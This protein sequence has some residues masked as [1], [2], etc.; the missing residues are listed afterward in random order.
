MVPLTKAAAQL[1]V[2][3]MASG[4]LGEGSVL[5][6][7]DALVR[8]FDCRFRILTILSHAAFKSTR[9]KYWKRKHKIL[10]NV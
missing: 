7:A 3:V 4:P 10:K 9:T 8:P 1:G 6:N 5:Q 2:G